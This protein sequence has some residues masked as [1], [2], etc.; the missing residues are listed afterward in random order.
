MSMTTA[1]D[2][3]KLLAIADEHEP[4]RLAH[5]VFDYYH[6]N[7]RADRTS[8]SQMYLHMGML[9]GAMLRLAKGQATV[10]W[11]DTREKSD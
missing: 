6:D 2:H 3:T 8:R 11:G 4:V 7:D 10:S 5:L 9:C 1:D